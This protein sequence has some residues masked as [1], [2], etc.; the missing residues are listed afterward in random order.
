MEGKQEALVKLTKFLSRWAAAN[1]PK[2]QEAFGVK[3]N[4][5]E[6][7]KMLVDIKLEEDMIKR[8]K[9]NLIL[10]TDM[11]FW[12][13]MYAKNQNALIPDAK[14]DSQSINAS[15]EIEVDLPEQKNHANTHK[16]T[17]LVY[18]RKGPVDPF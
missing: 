1:Q 12:H 17:I 7:E 15:F 4:L 8:F 16:K 6:K 3:G 13:I 18:Q 11:C 9:M 10:Y 2:L 14:Q 5:D